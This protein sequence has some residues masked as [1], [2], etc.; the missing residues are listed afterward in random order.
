MAL[1][2]Y[3]PLFWIILALAIVF[4]V[5]LRYRLKLRWWPAWIIRGALIAVILGVIFF[6]TEKSPQSIATDN[7]ILIVDCSESISPD[8]KVDVKNKILEWQKGNPNGMVILSGSDASLYF[9]STEPCETVDTQSSHLEKALRLA[10]SLISN[11]TNQLSSTITLVSDGLATDTSTVEEEVEL[12]STMG[13]KMDIVPLSPRSNPNDVYVGPLETSSITWANSPINI[14]LPVYNID[15]TERDLLSF[16]IQ[17]N[18]EESNISPIS[19]NEGYFIFQIPAQPSG[20]I[21]I[22]M[23]VNAPTDPNDTNNTS[24]ASLQVLDSPKVLWISETTKDSFLVNLER[25]GL[26][27][28]FSYPDKISS[29]AADLN[30]YGVIFVNNILATR[31]TFEQM[32]A[33]RSFV[34]DRGGG[35]IFLGGNNSYTLGGYE[36]TILEPILPVKLE[37]PPR[38]KRDPIVFLLVLDNSGSMSLGTSIGISALDLGKEAAMR[39]IELLKPEDH[40]GILAFSDDPIWI[41]PISPLNNEIAIRNASDSLK[42]IFPDNGTY[43]YKALVESVAALQNISVDSA[44]HRQILLLSDGRA[45]DGT[46]EGY[47]ELALLAKTQGTRIST[48]ALGSDVNINLMKSI[49]DLSGGRNYRAPTA[50]D[51]PRIM[52]N[53]SR[54]ARSENIQEGLTSLNVSESD[55]PILTGVDQAS[56]PTLNSYNALTSKKSEGAEDILVSSSQGD[57]ILSIWQVGLGRVVTWMSDVDQ[58][59]ANPWGSEVDEQLFWSQV[60]RYALLN[61]TIGPAQADVSI[62]E[63]DVTVNLTLIDDLGGPLN[64]A[65]PQFLIVD[66]DQKSTSLS[67][68]QVGSGFYRLTIP[69]LNQ[70]AYRTLITYTDRQGNSKQLVVPFSMNMNWET[71]PVNEIEKEQGISNLMLWAELSGGDDISDSIT[72][73][74]QIS[75]QDEP[76]VDLRTLLIILLI[77]AWPVEIAIR[78]RWLPWNSSDRIHNFR[79]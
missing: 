76:T 51:L 66:S 20:V 42:N 70:G 13:I 22:K 2:L 16:S 47:E 65:N 21:T 3:R 29:D 55:H 19:S 49:S 63:D 78:R 46:F 44:Q 32:N 28:E 45:A 52:I 15:S 39:A 72:T 60:V 54:A 58:K 23:S 31:F 18:D 79:R 10:R 56:L 26:N 43:M 75:T 6:S 30:Q 73:S 48:I 34:N 35:L 64:F 41:F 53:E 57:P 67:I 17:I 27:V 24:Y 50:E 71:H 25:S 62:S 33:L 69:N 36:N 14:I 7:R 38:P 40:L 37:P 68:P 4:L 77:V 5:W 8:E 11:S 59:W 61:P 1:I 12:L 9:S 74:S